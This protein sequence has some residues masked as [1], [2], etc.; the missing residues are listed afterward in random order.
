MELRTVIEK[1]RS[2]RAY[3]E[4]EVPVELIRECVEAAR[5]APSACNQQPWRFIA[6]TEPELRKRLC[7]ETLLPGIRMTWLEQAPV[8][9]ALC[10]KKKLPVHFFAPLLSGIH[11]EYIDLGIAGEHFVLAAEDRGLG[12]CWI[13]WINA[14]KVKKLL[15]L[16][17][18]VT[19]VS[20]I[21][22]GFPAEEVPPRPRLALDEILKLL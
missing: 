17:F 22:L 16:P 7:R 19:P 3:L 21:S 20:L 18:D 11:Y 13:G 1:R 4:R 10:M 9:M 15:S 14:A 8:I 2:C 6:V 12:T 5:L